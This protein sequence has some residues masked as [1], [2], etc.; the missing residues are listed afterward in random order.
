MPSPFYPI[1]ARKFDVPIYVIG[2]VLSSFSVV[3]IPGSPIIGKYLEKI[4]RRN[5]YVI[6][7]LCSFVGLA[8]WG[9]LPY[10]DYGLFI[11]LSF[12]GRVFMGLGN[13]FI[14]L[15][16]TTIAASDYPDD[17]GKV[18]G[19][20]ESVG[21]IG[22]IAGPL[23]GAGI[24][25]GVGFSLT[26]FLYS[27]I[28]LIGAPVFF[29]LLGKDR[30]YVKEQKELISIWVMSR[31]V[32]VLFQLLMALWGLLIIM[33]LDTVIAI[34]L[35]EKYGLHSSIIGLIYALLTLFYTIGSIATG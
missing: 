27:L 28:F 5:A 23:I 14:L 20:M 2:L 3:S 21:G 26:F 31:R 8:T 10:V 18:M 35:N 32:K 1:E 19:Y 34:Q 24:Y 15:T 6:S 17:I 12:I 25:Y 30:P 16:G 29:F 22:L 7:M 11:A 33:S 9:V 4:G 13:V